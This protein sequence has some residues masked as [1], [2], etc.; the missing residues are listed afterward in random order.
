MQAVEC[1]VRKKAQVFFTQLFN[2]MLMF[3]ENRLQEIPLPLYSSQTLSGVLCPV[4]GYL[5]QERQGTTAESP[6]EGYKD[7]YRSL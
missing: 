5:V 2:G 7:D 1:Q 4:L 6:A 3:L